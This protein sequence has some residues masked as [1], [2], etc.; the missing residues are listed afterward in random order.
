MVKYMEI[1]IATILLFIVI[2]RI[3]PVD[4]L[5]CYNCDTR[6]PDHRAVC[7]EHF[8]LTKSNTSFLL[9]NCEYCSK[10]H[11]TN[12]GDVIRNCTLKKEKSFTFKFG[13]ENKEVGGETVKICACEDELCNGAR[14]HLT[15]MI[16]VY[17]LV[18]L[19][20]FICHF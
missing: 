15:T 20:I 19:V 4:G 11:F 5:K 7:G 3:G 8:K 17:L 12:T 14:S 1:S 9:D 13:C 2:D 10:Y 18:F 6:K 16:L